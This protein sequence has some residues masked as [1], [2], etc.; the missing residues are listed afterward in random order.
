MLEY[1]HESGE[2]RLYDTM[3][4]HVPGHTDHMSDYK[5]LW[6][7]ETGQSKQTQF[8]IAHFTE[9]VRKHKLP[10][11]NGRAALQG[12]RVIWRMYDAERSNT[13]ADL[14]GLGLEQI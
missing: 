9:C 5:V 12:L 10:L 6:R 1:E 7:R 11:T 4:A 2:L 3:A 8:E 14:R 13:V